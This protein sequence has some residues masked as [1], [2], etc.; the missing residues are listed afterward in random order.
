MMTRRLYA[1]FAV[2]AACVAMVTLTGCLVDLANDGEAGFKQCS[3]WSFYH[4][5]K[6]TDATSTAELRSQP[7]EEWIKSRDEGAAEVAMPGTA[8]RE[9]D[10]PAPGG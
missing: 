10:D 9:P 5:A 2:F 3:T 4:T 7:L 8:I 6:K 1:V